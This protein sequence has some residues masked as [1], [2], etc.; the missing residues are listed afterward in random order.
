MEILRQQLQQRDSDYEKDLLRLRAQT[1]GGDSRTNLQDNIDMIRLQ[2]DLRD[3]SDELRR[4]QGQSTN[5]ESVC[6]I[7]NQSFLINLFIFI[8]KS[9]SSSH[10]CR[11]IKRNR[12]TR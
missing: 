11:I 6:S 1:S 9:F 8:A 4:L 5:L 3:K 10:K 2:R 12:S 7:A